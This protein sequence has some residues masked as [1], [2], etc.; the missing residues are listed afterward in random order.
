MGIDVEGMCPLVQVFD[1]PTALAF[2][3]D[4]LGFAV[5]QAAPAADE[6]DWCV[7]RLGKSQL[8]LNT[9]YERHER[10][11]LPDAARVVG[12]GD[13]SLFFQCRD[14]DAVYSHLRTKGIDATPPVDREYGMRQVYCRDPDGYGLCFQWPNGSSQVLDVMDATA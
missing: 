8:M 12:H 2:Y 4:I 6:C 9:Q 5:V 10:P 1:M 3:R 14:L 11:Q 7:L 13:T